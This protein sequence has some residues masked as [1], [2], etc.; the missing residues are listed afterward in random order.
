MILVDTGYLVA[1]VQVRDE[2][3]ERAVR[4]TKTIREPLVVTEYVLWEMVNSL[5]HP[6]D[7]PKAHL[8]LDYISSHSRYEVVAASSDL[9][10]SGLRLHAER[11][12]K[13]WSLTDC[14][15]FVLMQD[16]GIHQ[17]L[18]FDHHFLQAGFDALLR[19]DPDS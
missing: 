7:R 13:A 2:L 15:S 5:S 11:N 17:A 19:R 4:W 9:M 3:H 12:D 1:F 18:A 16:R 14:V 10:A 8:L 6:L